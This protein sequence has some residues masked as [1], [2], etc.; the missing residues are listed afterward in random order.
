MSF[1]ISPL[2][3]IALAL[4]WL[5]MGTAGGGCTDADKPV[6]VD[7]SQAPVEEQK[8]IAVDE[9]VA[10]PQP[11]HLVKPPANPRLAITEALDAG[12]LRPDLSKNDNLRAILE[13]A[14]GKKA[15]ERPNGARPEA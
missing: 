13:A 5:L 12:L 9:P 3:P 2:K 1:Y 8:S 7:A 14:G 4:L 6:S 10:P 11:D 15:S